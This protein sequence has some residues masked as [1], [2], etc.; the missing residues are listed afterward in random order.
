MQQSSPFPFG[1]GKG[2]HRLFVIGRDVGQCQIPIGVPTSISVNRHNRRLSA[3]MPRVEGVGGL[4]L[5]EDCQDQN[6]KRKFLVLLW[7]R[8]AASLVLPPVAF[9]MLLHQRVG[10]G[11]RLETVCRVAQVGSDV[12]QHGAHVWDMQ[13]CPGGSLGSNPLTYLCQPLLALALHG[14]RLPTVARSIGSPEGKSLLT[15]SLPV[16]HRLFGEARLCVMMRPVS[17]WRINAF[18]SLS[19]CSMSVNLMPFA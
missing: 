4:I 5:P 2:L 11:Q 10:L 8:I 6:H 1:E 16:V 17:Q 3:G 18:F 12:R 7:H 15:R 19:T 14:Q 9:L 13:R